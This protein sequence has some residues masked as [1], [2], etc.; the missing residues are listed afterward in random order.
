M[1]FS[2]FL[3]T[4][5]N[6]DLNTLF[7]S[8]IIEQRYEIMVSILRTIRH[9]KTSLV[10]PINQPSRE[11][12]RTLQ[13]EAVLMVSSTALQVQ[14]PLPRNIS[15]TFFGFPP[16]GTFHHTIAIQC[17]VYN[18]AQS[19]SVRAL[20]QIPFSDTKKNIGERV[21]FGSGASGFETKLMITQ[22]CYGSGS[23]VNL[24]HKQKQKYTSKKF[25]I[26]Q[27]ALNPS[28]SALYNSRLTHH[29]DTK[30]GIW[31]CF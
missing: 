18:T 9:R 26:R 6:A 23:K 30:R 24:V 7:N 25:S 2:H 21:G 27:K 10:V 3:S 29:T 12:L 16:L 11:S 5:Y 15:Q 4:F 19:S 8:D 1:K 22:L 14:F 13:N 17:W 20:Q 31:G 28:F